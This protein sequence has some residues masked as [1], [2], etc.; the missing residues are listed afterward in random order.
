MARFESIFNKYVKEKDYKYNPSQSIADNT[1]RLQRMAFLENSCRTLY[2]RLDGIYGESYAERIL[3]NVL[4]KRYTVTAFEYYPMPDVHYCENRIYMKNYLNVAPKPM[5]STIE[6]LTLITFYTSIM[7]ELIA[8]AKKG[9]HIELFDF[10]ICLSMYIDKWKITE[11]PKYL[12]RNVYSDDFLAQILKHVIYSLFTKPNEINTITLSIMDKSVFEKI[13]R[14]SEYKL[15][16]NLEGD[17]IQPNYDSYIQTIELFLRYLKTTQ[18]S[19]QLVQPNVKVYAVASNKLRPEI[20]ELISSETGINI[21]VVDDI[22]KHIQFDAM[23]QDLESPE[24]R[25]CWEKLE[26]IKTP[27]KVDWFKTRCKI[28]LI[29]E[30]DYIQYLNYRDK[31]LAYLFHKYEVD[32][33]LSSL[34]VYFVKKQD[35]YTEPH[36]RHYTSE[37][38]I[39]FSDIVEGTESRE[40]YKDRLIHAYLDAQ[41]INQVRDT[42]VDCKKDNRYNVKINGV[43]P[44]LIS[45]T[46]TILDEQNTW[47]RNT[48][49]LNFTFNICQRMFFRNKGRKCYL[50]L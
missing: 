10:F 19:M 13:A 38:Q 1:N 3:T 6:S 22:F 23:P 30:K 42:I 18:N 9:G 11:Y 49:N 44:E 17:I 39:E 29:F 2:E 40:E 48:Y 4:E 24:Y 47:L 8:N 36:H 37:V 21:S 43:D 7:Q 46:Y 32:N 35:T 34:E 33:L 31:K 12:S 50:L 41:A 16:V 5:K 28:N 45:Y 27:K 26:E 25:A 20:L 15:I 14:P